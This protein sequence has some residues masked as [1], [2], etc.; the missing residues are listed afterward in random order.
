MLKKIHREGKERHILSYSYMALLKDC[1]KK[2]DL[3]QGTKL[4]A[5][6]IKRGLLEKNPYLATTLINMYAKCGVLAK[7]QKVL[8]E[9][10]IRD[11]FS[12]NA[13][14]AGYAE[15]GHSNKVLECLEQMQREN[16]SPDDVTFLSILNACSRTGKSAEA[17][18]YY[19]TMSTKYGIIPK[20]EHHTCM[21]VIFGSEGRF[22][23]AMSMIE[24]MPSLNDPSVWLALLSACKK[25]GNV[26]LG[27]L[28]FDNV[29]RLDDNV[30]V[31]YVFMASIYA[32]ADMQEEAQSVKS[33]RR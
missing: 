33:I 9:L 2:K 1:T 26:K 17:Q 3:Q 30:G 28:A 6:I 20:V 19:E 29:T 22:D 24:T 23:K 32:A 16:L 4:H 10:P 31:A 13:L 11:T 15:E 27:R 18:L 8:E 25:W 7:A 12:W 5:D 14:I 21:V